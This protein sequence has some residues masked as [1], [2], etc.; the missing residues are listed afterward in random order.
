MP[1]R[2]PLDV[3]LDEKIANTTDLSFEE[4]GKLREE[5]NRNN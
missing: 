2:N 5:K 3:L 4:V 1:A